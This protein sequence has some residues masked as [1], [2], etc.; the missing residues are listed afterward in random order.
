M[1]EFEHVCVH[2]CTPDKYRISLYLIVS[3]TFEIFG[4]LIVYYRPLT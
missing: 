2:K 3:L 1:Y 4:L